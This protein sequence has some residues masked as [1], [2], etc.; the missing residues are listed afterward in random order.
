MMNSNIS[1]LKY[2]SPLFG[3]LFCPITILFVWALWSGP[4]VNYETD[5]VEDVQS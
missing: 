4:V 1:W 2:L 5:L 3:L